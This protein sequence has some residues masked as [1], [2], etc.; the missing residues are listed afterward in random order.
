[1]ITA[2]IMRT[3]FG[4]S[5]LE[6]SMD[7]YGRVLGLT[8]VIPPE[9]ADGHAAPRTAQFALPAPGT[10]GAAQLLELVEGQPLSHP[11]TG[12]ATASLTL[13]VTDLDAHR[14]RLAEAGTVVGPT[15]AGAGG[16]VGRL[17]DP[18]GITLDLVQLP[19]KGPAVDAAAASAP[20]RRVGLHSVLPPE[21]IAGYRADHRRV[22]ADLLDAFARVG[23]RDWE[24]WRSGRHLFHLVTCDDFEAAIDGLADDPANLAWQAV[25]GVH[26]AVFEGPE[27]EAAFERGD[28]V[29]TLHD[30]LAGR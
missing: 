21:S 19:L 1:M 23:I 2:G 4:V 3:T 18:D 25:I 9:P 20:P 22:P 7:W 11:T 15:T 28:R 8:P 13:V 6:R 14:A 30:Q 27:G 10:G 16:A 17:Q 26:G 5:D 29:W 12:R 24:I